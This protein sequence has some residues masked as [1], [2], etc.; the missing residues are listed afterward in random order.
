MIAGLLEPIV[1]EILFNGRPLRDDLIGY[2]RRMGYVVLEQSQRV[3][4]AFNQEP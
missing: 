1:G 4:N 3:G 2:K